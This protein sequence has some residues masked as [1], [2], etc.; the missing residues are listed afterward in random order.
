M[1][2]DPPHQNFLDA[3]PGAV[4]E[5][6]AVRHVG[7]ELLEAV[8]L[9][10]LPG[11]VVVVEAGAVGGVG[12]VAVVALHAPA[13]LTLLARRTRVQRPHLTLTIRDVNEISRS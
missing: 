8:L 9:A 7:V 3:A 1:I 4:E 12:A 13:L 5:A 10:P 2:F 6:G 11:E